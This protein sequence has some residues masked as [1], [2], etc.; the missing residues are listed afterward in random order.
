MCNVS[1]VFMLGVQWILPW[2]SHPEAAAIQTS[3][4]GILEDVRTESSHVQHWC[5]IGAG[6]QPLP[7]CSPTLFLPALSAQERA[8]PP[9]WYLE[10]EISREEDFPLSLGEDGCGGNPAPLPTDKR[11]G[12]KTPS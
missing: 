7:S 10:H 8:Q 3:L 6:D 5:K 9:S 1:G 2:H 4:P 12:G 11:M